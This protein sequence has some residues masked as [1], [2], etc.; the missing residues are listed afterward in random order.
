MRVDIVHSVGGRPRLVFDAKYKAAGPGDTYPNA[1]H[2]Q[3]LAYSTALRVPTAWLVYAGGGRPKVRKIRYTD[4]EV[5]EY[6][7]DLRAELLHLLEQIDL[8][9]RRAWARG[10]WGSRE[11]A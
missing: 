9:A 11:S 10:I 2:Y 1:D 8:L 7:L 5:V 3:M 6:P 4:V